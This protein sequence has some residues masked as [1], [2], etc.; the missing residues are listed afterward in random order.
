MKYIGVTLIA[1]G[2]AFLV[3]SLISFIHS[4]NQFHSPIPFD[5]GVKV[6]IITPE[7]GR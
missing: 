4:Q 1:I 5:K 6:I 3:F 2:L 7:K